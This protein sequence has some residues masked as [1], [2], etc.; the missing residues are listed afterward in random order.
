[1]VGAIRIAGPNWLRAVVGRAREGD[2]VAESEIMSSTSE[3]VCELWSGRSIVRLLGSPDLLEL[4]YVPYNQ[5]R[6][7]SLHEVA[8]FDLA[9]AVNNDH[10]HASNG[11]R[12][13]LGVMLTRKDPPNLS[14]SVEGALCGKIELWTFAV[15]GIIIQSAVI[16]YSI[17]AVQF[18]QLPKGGSRVSGY[19]LPCTLIG[20]LLIVGGLLICSHVRYRDVF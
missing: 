3:S 12:E 5:N 11:S 7:G 10:L 1:M 14:L 13:A 8:V 19:A 15:I 18:L 4:V 17:V 9:E 2:G 20:M 6:E 16:A